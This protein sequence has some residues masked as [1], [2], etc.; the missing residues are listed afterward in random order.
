MKNH[1]MQILL[2]EDQAR[3]AEVFRGMLQEQDLS[4]FELRHVAALK[5][6]LENVATGRA[7]LVV[8]E[9]DLPDAHGS[10]V[11][12]QIRAVAPYVPLVVVMDAAAQDLPMQALREGA[13][14]CLMKGDLDGRSLLRAIRLAVEHQ[15][16]L[17]T[18]RNP[19][20]LDRLTLLL[21]RPGF[22]CLGDHHLRLA[23][24]TG[25]DF[26]VFYVDVDGLKEINESQ[27]RPRGD[28]ALM[29]T[30]GILRASFRK[31]DVIARIGDDEFAVLM[32]DA[33][34]EAIHIV[35]P[36]LR[37]I[38]EHLNSRPRRRFTLALS[39]G[40]VACRARQTFALEEP[41]AQAEALMRK[42]KERKDE[43]SA[44]RV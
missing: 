9:L 12:R 31:S 20:L 26:V 19:D 4:G 24:F 2:V 7:D 14:E 34:A 25:N 17:A 43:C 39:T 15:R 32:I 30:S 11:I 33:P 3:D 38:L 23:R 10:D 29:E 28:E 40:V 5:D 42:E 8:T 21:N 13:Q 36:R 37:G 27:G 41:L 16:L 22:Q 6:A 18:I 1:L 35:R 44:V